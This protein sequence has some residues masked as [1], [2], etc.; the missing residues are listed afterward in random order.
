MVT[1]NGTRKTGINPV[2]FAERLTALG[3]GE[4]VVNSVDCDGEMSG[5]DFNLV[6]PIRQTVHLP[7]TV[8]GGAGSIYRAV[9]INNPNR[10]EKEDLLRQ[11]MPQS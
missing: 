1:Y 10:E 4:I 2:T 7:L 5:Y 11:I 9:L 8:L 6:D 3:A